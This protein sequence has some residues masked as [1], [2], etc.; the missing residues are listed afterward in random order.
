MN[1][2]DTGDDEVH[3]DYG[4]EECKTNGGVWENRKVN[5][6]NILNGMLTLFILSTLEGWP[7]IMYW[8]IDA[9][10]AGPIKGA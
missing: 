8:F 3:Y 4:P 2:C 5:F 9:D 10:E 1:Y 7:D 6:D